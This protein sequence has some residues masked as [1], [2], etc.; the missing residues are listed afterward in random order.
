MSYVISRPAASSER[1]SSRS[2][3]RLLQ[4]LECLADNHIPMRLQD[5]SK[6]V[7]MTQ[8]T[9]L[10]YLYSL[11]DANYVYQEEDTQRYALTWRACKLSN[12]LDSSLSLRTITTP[13][14]NR[15]A[16]ELSL[17]ICLVVE[18]DGECFYL[19]CVDNTNS[20]MPQRIGKQAP[21][22]AT[23]SGKVLLTRYNEIQLNEF[24]SKKGLAKCTEYTITDP[25]ELKRELEIIRHRGYGLDEEECELGLRCISMP[26]RNY[27]EQI[28]AALSVFGSTSDITDEVIQNKI[29]PLLKESTGLISL[30]LG[31]MPR[32]EA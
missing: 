27:T 26:L 19:D 18:Q 9:V 24:I 30:R 1:Q 5:L 11:Q 13:F 31:F 10:R 3:L 25:T 15:L 32:A 23:G 14:I 8:P 21:L 16:N 20:L 2:S 22:H 28:V 12:S 4:I 6:K 17:G 29:L 7:G